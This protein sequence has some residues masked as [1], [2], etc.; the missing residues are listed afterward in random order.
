MAGE[1]RERVTLFCLTPV[2]RDRRVMNSCYHHYYKYPR[3]TSL[4]PGAV[5]DIIALPSSTALFQVFI[6]ILQ[7]QNLS[8][9]V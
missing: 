2:T 1:G 7:D 6:I 8:T 5:T 4:A 3:L 9:Y